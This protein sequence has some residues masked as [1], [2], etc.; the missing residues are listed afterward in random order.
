[1]YVVTGYQE[2]DII[3]VQKDKLAAAVAADEKRASKWLREEYQ[4]SVCPKAFK[5]H[6]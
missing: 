3:M 4:C 1:M 2:E 5:V 6:R